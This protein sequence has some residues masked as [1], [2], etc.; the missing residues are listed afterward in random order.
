MRRW[1][2]ILAAVALAAC[3]DSTDPNDGAVPDGS[4]NIL[5]FASANPVTV[6]TA[7]FWAVKG[8]NRKLELFYTSG[9]RFLE[10]EVRNESL[11]ARPN[12]VPF[13][14]GDSVLISVSIDA[15]GKVAVD[16]Q[17]SG[18]KFNPLDPARLRIDYQGAD[19][20]VDHDGD[21]DSEDLKL[22]TRL[23]IWQQET[24][25]MP[26]LPLLTVRLNGDDMEARVLGFTGF[27]MASN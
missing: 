18:L 19:H 20:D 17:P 16:F 27:A 24:A 15:S 11:L 23:R 8:D 21:T 7:S 12:G 3:S 26:W 5:R 4:L 14:D 9:D 1:F 10:F 13:V 25:G 6:Q 22:E 2:W